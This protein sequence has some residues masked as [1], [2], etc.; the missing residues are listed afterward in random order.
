M[1]FRDKPAFVVFVAPEYWLF[2]FFT[3]DLWDRMA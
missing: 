2:C 3:C 1:A